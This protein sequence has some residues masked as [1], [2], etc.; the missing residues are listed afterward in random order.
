[1][2]SGR[3]T[4]NNREGWWRHNPMGRSRSN[5]SRV[6]GQYEGRL[7]L[8]WTNKHQSLLAHDDGK[9]E[10]VPS[11][12]YRVA[13]VRLLDE[14]ELVGD[15]GPDR[16]SDNLLIR[17]DALHALTSLS[18]LPEFTDSLAG[19]VQ[20]AYID[21]PFNTQQAFENYDDALEHSVWLTLMRDRIV[22][23]RKLLS[24]TGSVWVH[25]DDAEMAYC[26]VMMDEIFGRENFV[27]NVIWQKLSTRENRTD[28]STIHDYIVV[29][30]K[31]RRMWGAHRNLLPYGE[32]QQARFQNP[33]EDPRGPWASLPA[34]GK[35]EK[36]RRASQFYTIALPSGR[37]VDPPP[38]RCWI[39]TRDRFDEKVADNR[40]W[41]GRTGDGVPRVKV[42]LSEVKQG[43]VPIS[44]WLKDEVGTTAEAKQEIVSLFPDQTP[45]STPKPERLIQRVLQIASNPGDIVLDCFLGSGTTAAVA[46]KMDR[47][48]IG[49]EWSADTVANFTRPRMEMVVQGADK[50]GISAEAQWSGGGGFRV[51]DVAPSMFTAADGM[52]FLADWAANTA[53]G[54][55]TAA[56]LGYE[57]EPDAPF[58]GRKGRTRLAVIDGLVN[59][60][61]VRLLVDRLIEKERLLVCGTAVE[62]E[63]ST[64]LRDSG[65]GSIR[66]I[67]A[68]I[69]R[70]YERPSR[71]RSL[72]QVALT[73][74][75]DRTIPE[76]EAVA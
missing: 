11:S 42:F 72:L 3:L 19:A 37:E 22:Q 34:H 15:V 55:A 21:P 5:G 74:G 43:L 66:K 7:E 56:Q 13:E 59:V 53:L 49:I 52:V 16:T 36:G 17:G 2:S 51:L 38:G 8:T 12:D 60:D 30:A 40:I 50:C 35:A 28:F 68:A 25:L 29:F 57:F 10:W 69:L 23:I 41:F 39:Y 26:R 14:V 76:P 73:E 31:N 20:V 33:D 45:F 61:V 75:A 47:R 54:E 6:N 64:F 24:E 48:W 1:M 44:L 9:Y 67:P 63:A 58:C 71:L 46:H 62:D 4:G 70:Y 27:G 65:R 32:E 18:D